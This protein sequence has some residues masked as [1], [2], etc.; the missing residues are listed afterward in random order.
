MIVT[1]TSTSSLGPPSGNSGGFPGVVSTTGITTLPALA[2][3]AHRKCEMP[4][5]FLGSAL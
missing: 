4:S 2:E 5:P 3:T 1:M